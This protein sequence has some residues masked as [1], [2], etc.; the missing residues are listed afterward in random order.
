MR[1]CGSTEEGLEIKWWKNRENKCCKF[2]ALP[3]YKANEKPISLDI[4]I[5]AFTRVNRLDH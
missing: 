1:V 4:N 5:H 2:L 3:V